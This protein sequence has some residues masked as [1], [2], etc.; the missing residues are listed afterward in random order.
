M[1]L[2]CVMTHLSKGREVFCTCRLYCYLEGEEGLDNVMTE[3]DLEKWT[4]KVTISLIHQRGMAQ[5]HLLSFSTCSG[6]SQ[7]KEFF[8]VAN[9]S[10]IKCTV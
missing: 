5:F 7:R 8:S 6:S 3:N 10:L 1:A 4:P 9:T 2:R